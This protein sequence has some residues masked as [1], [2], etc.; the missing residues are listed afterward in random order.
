[1]KE[2]AVRGW[3]RVLGGEKGRRREDG[4]DMRWKRRGVGWW[5]CE[6][7]VCVVWMVVGEVG[8]RK[9]GR[10]KTKIQKV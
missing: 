1:M 7:G 2:P 6:R 9:K 3:E 5:W 10:E 8:E 4:E